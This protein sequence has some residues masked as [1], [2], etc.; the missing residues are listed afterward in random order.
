MIARNWFLCIAVVCLLVMFASAAVF[1]RQLWR[2]RGRQWTKRRVRLV[3]AYG[4]M[5][6]TQVCCRGAVI[7][8]N[9]CAYSYSRLLCNDSRSDSSCVSV[10]AALQFSV[11]PGAQCR[12]A[13]Q[14]VLLVR[15]FLRPAFC[16]QVRFRQYFGAQFLIQ[17][18]PAD[19][20]LCVDA[21][22]T[23]PS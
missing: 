13:V 15:S 23:R 5:L 10:P 8:A 21:A 11:F 17:T 20:R 7:H 19:E 9:I 1:V 22:G 12:A 6:L 3:S 2:T 16:S 4:T 14:R 18:A